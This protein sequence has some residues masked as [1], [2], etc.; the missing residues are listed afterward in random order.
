MTNRDQPWTVF[1]PSRQA[2]IGRLADIDPI[3]IDAEIMAR[4]SKDG[5]DGARRP[6]SLLSPYIRH[7]VITEQEVLASVLRSG[8]RR[9]SAVFIETLFWRAYWKGW[10]ELR[11][12]VWD[13]FDKSVETLIAAAAGN[14]SNTLYARAQL[15]A[16]GIDCFDAWARQL[17][18]TGYLH[19]QARR[20][21]ASI[22]IHTLRL[23]WELGA[24]HMERHLLDGDPAINLLSWRWVA[25]LQDP[26]APQLITKEEISR[27]FPG[28]FQPSGLAVSPAETGDSGM[29]GPGALPPGRSLQ[30]MYRAPGLLVTLEDLRPEDL[31]PANVGIRAIG[32][33]PEA[34]PSDARRSSPLVRRFRAGLIEDA[35]ARL[36][37]FYGA[38]VTVLGEF[39]GAA[40]VAWARK[41]GLSDVLVP[42]SPIG[43]VRRQMKEVRASLG[44]IRVRMAVLRRGWD[45]VL[46]IH[47][48]GTYPDFRGRIPALIGL[49]GRT[50]GVKLREASPGR[51]PDRK[52]A[53]DESA[54]VVKHFTAQKRTTRP[55]VVIVEADRP[56]RSASF[57]RPGST[58]P[59]RGSKKNR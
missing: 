3:V 10:L 13:V 28:R 48:K 2:A 36:S 50:S 9:K 4:R 38:P 12:H 51:M 7:R 11:P 22:W 19:H 27:V 47:S 30:D 26:R 29:P 35:A 56:A 37:T 39:S 5:I 52:P 43:L 8:R 34:A 54:P 59:N 44:A 1:Q 6:T 24:D 45:S 42:Y 17:A 15:G 33:L 40:A 25:G 20:A 18:E 58:G 41:A 49:L 21:Y 16:T 53:G 14:A 31:I 46:W 55:R 57:S 32:I 23:P